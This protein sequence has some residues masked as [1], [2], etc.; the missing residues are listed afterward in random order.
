MHPTKRPDRTVALPIDPAAGNEGASARR[1]PV[2]NA[3]LKAILF[4]LLVCLSLA[5]I[6]GWSLWKARTARMQEASTVT[7]NMTRALAQHATDTLRAA[8]SVLLGLVE[9]LEVDGMN[10]A[11]LPRLKK[12][13][14]A[15][16]AELGS[17]NGIFVYD[18]QG[19]WVVHSQASTPKNVN[20]GD[21]EYFLYHKL[22]LDHSAHV[23]V[24][25]ESRS[26]GRWVIPVS[27]RLNH[28]DGTFAGVVLATVD[29]AYFR[30]FHDSFDIGERGVILLA[31]DNG[32]MLVRRPFNTSQIGMDISK[33]PVFTQLRTYGPGTRL[34]TSKVDQITRMYSYM[35]VRHYPL[36]VSMAL[37]RDDI[38]AN[39]WQEAWWTAAVIVALIVV[40]SGFGFRLVRQISVR[41][42][43]EAEL[44]TAKRTLE[45]LNRSLE[46]LS[47]EDSLTGLGNRRRFDL[48]LQAECAHSARHGTPLALVM[49]D[50]DHFK[51]YNDLYGHPAGDECLRQVGAAVKSA[52][53]RA[54]DVAA[55]YGGEEIAVLLPQTDLGGAF[56]AAERLR[57]AVEA[58]GVVHAGSPFGQVTVSIGVASFAPSDDPA[59]PARLLRSADRALYQAKAG[60]RN[61]V[62]LAGQAEQSEAETVHAGA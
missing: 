54:G 44:R 25:I 15:S 2:G 28:P 30:A 24:P 17:L 21:R 50:V 23:G 56:A 8:D 10:E 13:L 11:S 45:D 16:V 32:T 51:R 4:V 26:T 20:N 18:E 61:Q 12:L 43:A 53:G 38:F 31:L 48:A 19:R 22:N 47:L 29:M 55:R 36:V 9:R 39:W 1:R 41:E 60:G 37:G 46:L 6:G 33:G 27:R 5:G 7:A 3:K 49:I 62:W 35:H 40:L 34:L 42:Q 59:A 52:R 57:L 58:T 14:Q